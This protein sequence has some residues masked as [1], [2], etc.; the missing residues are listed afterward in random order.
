MCVGYQL[1]DNGVISGLISG[2]ISKLCA[3]SCTESSF[4]NV[5]RIP[6]EPSRTIKR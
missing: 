3:K 5:V 2:R 1:I 4:L 6:T